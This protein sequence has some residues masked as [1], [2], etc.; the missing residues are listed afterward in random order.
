MEDVF[1]NE[2]ER[3][4]KVANLSKSDIADML[5]VSRQCYSMWVHSKKFPSH[6]ICDSTI[7]MATKHPQLVDVILDEML[8]AGKAEQLNRI[9]SA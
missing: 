3:R 8:A 1:L 9:E 7:K 2:L 4:R 5:K 6:V